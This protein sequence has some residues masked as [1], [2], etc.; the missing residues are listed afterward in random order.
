[1]T[2]LSSLQYTDF[3]FCFVPEMLGG[4]QIRELKIL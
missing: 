3:V 2:F 4:G 1:M